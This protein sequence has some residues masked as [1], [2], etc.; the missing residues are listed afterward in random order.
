[1][2]KLIKSSVLAALLAALAAGT[3]SANEGPGRFGHH[4]QGPERHCAPGH[5]D[6]LFHE[7][8]VS[9]HPELKELFDG[10]ARLRDELFVEDQVLEAY[11]RSPEKA[12]EVRSQAQKIVKLRRELAARQAEL[13]AK[14]DELRPQPEFTEGQGPGPRGEPGG[15]EG[16]SPRGEPPRDQPPADRAAGSREGAESAPAPQKRVRPPFR[17]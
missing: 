13:G 8:L 14:L 9:E 16:F 6:R 2:N 5:P 3:A 15:D 7:K 11:R 17:S 4:A 12:D 1:M 10:T